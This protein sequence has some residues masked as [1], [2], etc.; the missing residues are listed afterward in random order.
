MPAQVSGV[1]RAGAQEGVGPAPFYALV[2]GQS[3][4]VPRLHTAVRPGSLSTFK[5]HQ[6]VPL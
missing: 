4:E 2:D 3:N 5:L 6:E 1:I